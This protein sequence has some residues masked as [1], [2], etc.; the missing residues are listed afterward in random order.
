MPTSASG[1][2]SQSDASKVEST[3]SPDFNRNTALRNRTH[4]AEFTARERSAIPDEFNTKFSRS[5]K[6][7]RAMSRVLSKIPSDPALRFD[8][9]FDRRRSRALEYRQNDRQIFW[10]QGK[11]PAG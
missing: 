1:A 2:K 4:L 5:G 6:W 11:T 8:G 9:I 10:P 3:Y 7:Y